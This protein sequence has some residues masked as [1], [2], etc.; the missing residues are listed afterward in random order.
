[1]SEELPPPEV[2][3]QVLAANWGISPETVRLCVERR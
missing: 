2:V 3:T 1:M